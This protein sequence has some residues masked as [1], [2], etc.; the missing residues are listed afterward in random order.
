MTIIVMAAQAQKQ[1]V[2]EKPSAFMGEY[3]SEFEITKVELK[4]TETVLHI[5]ANYM[6][7]NWIRFDKNSYVKTPDGK[8]YG[9]TSGAK[10]DETESDLQLDSLF[11]MPQSG[12][13]NLA[14][15]FNP[16]P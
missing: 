11:W 10:T 13:A 15:H 4:Q 7:G 9:I 6:P 14:L 2:W 3:N 1:V 16:L 12:K 5:L 8:R